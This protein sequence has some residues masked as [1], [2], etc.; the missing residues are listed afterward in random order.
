MAGTGSESLIALAHVR[1]IMIDLGHELTPEV[2]DT[3]V[4]LVEVIETWIHQ[5]L[6]THDG[7][8]PAEL[9]ATEEG[10]GHVRAELA[11][12][13]AAPTLAHPAAEPPAPTPEA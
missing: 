13:L 1:R 11:R 8:T 10:L 12:L 9:V 5:P 2:L 3:E 6:A 4:P 7:K